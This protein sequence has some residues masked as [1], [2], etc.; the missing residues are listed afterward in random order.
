MAYNNNNRRSVSTNI[1]TL[2]G[3]TASMSLSYWN[4]M[5]SIKMNPCTGTNADGVRQYDRNRSFSTA[6]SIQK[7]KAL[8]DLLEENI[9]PEIKKVAEGGKLEAPVN[10][11]VQCGS[12]KAMVIIQYNNDDRG[13]PFVC[14]YG[15]TSS[16]DD[17]T[18]DQQ[19]MYAYKFGKTNV[20]KNYNPNT[21]E[22]DTVQVESE[23]EFFYNVLKN[24][25]SAFGAASHSTN[26]FTSWS[27][28][29]GNDGNSNGNAPSNLG[30][31]FPGSNSN[32]GGAFGNDD[33]PF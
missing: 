16:N 7:S 21:G 5:I 19:N 25:A 10:V 23:F 3:D 32:S 14:L 22:G 17:G 20:I 27:N 12:K 4:D 31:N 8:V 13:K 26:Y 1:K 30:N 33:M 29:M 24:Q 18:C 15:Y 6:L 9:L 11:A 28:G 2:Y